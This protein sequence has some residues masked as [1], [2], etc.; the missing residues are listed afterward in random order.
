MGPT[1]PQFW[2]HGEPLRFAF[3]KPQRRGA[4]VRG[5]SVE[6]RH[7]KQQGPGECVLGFFVGSL[8]TPSGM[9]TCMRVQSSRTTPRHAQ[10]SPASRRT[11]TSSASATLASARPT[12]RT[13]RAHV[14]AKE[15]SKMV[16]TKMHRKVQENDGAGDPR[17][18]PHLHGTVHRLSRGARTHTAAESRQTK[19][20]LSM[21]G[22]G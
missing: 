18:F 2:G 8:Q 7:T 16:I 14:A 22:G 12:P 11:C 10:C 17:V 13:C 3:D 9:E 19:R 1:Y 6:G 21:H 5:V 4:V 15:I 20:T